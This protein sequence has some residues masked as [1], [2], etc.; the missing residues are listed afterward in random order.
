MMLVTGFLTLAWV[1]S[2]NVFI[3]YRKIT[4]FYV[5]VICTLY[6]LIHVAATVCVNN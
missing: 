5:I 3:S 4:E 6:T 2:A 1:L